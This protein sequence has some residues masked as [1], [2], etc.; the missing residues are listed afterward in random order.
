MEFLR[1]LLQDMIW[2][3]LPDAGRISD[4]ECSAEE[5]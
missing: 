4:D 5:E 2:M 3:M 1:S